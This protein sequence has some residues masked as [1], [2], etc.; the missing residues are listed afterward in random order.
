MNG[1]MG[2]ITYVD[3]TTGRIWDE[4]LND[5]FARKYLGGNGFGARILLDR[6]PK[7]ADPLGPENALI[8]A[9]GPLSGTTAHGS[10]RGAV[11]TKSPL[12]GLFMDSYFGGDFALKLKQSGRDAVVVMGRSPRPVVLLLDEKGPSILPAEDLWGL[13][14]LEVQDRLF[15]R[16]GGDISVLCCGPAGERLVPIACTIGGRRAAG[17]GGTGAVMGSKNLKAMAARGLRDIKVAD[18]K[19]LLRHYRETKERFLGLKSL[20]DIGTPYLVRIVNEFGGLGTRNWREETFEGADRI[21]GERLLEEHFV[22]HWAC[23]ACCMGGCTKVVRA[24]APGEVL[25]EGPEY[26]TLFALGSNCAVEELDWII[27]ADRICDDLGIDT[28]SFGSTLAFLMECYENGLITKEDTGGMELEFGKG[29]LLVECAK[30]TARREGIGELLAL[31]VRGASERIGQGSERLACHVRGLEPAGHSARALKCMG[32]GY[33]V[34]PRGGSHHDTRPG[35]EYRMDKSQR[36]S[37]EGKAR[38]A[39]ETSN[40]TAIGDSMVVCHFCEGVYGLTLQEPH[41][42]LVRLA[43]GWDVTLEELTGI[44]CRIHNAERI[45]N[46]R[47]G[48]SRKDDLLPLRFMEEEIPEGNSSGLATRPDELRQMLDEYYALRGWDER[49]LPREDTLKGLGMEELA[50][51]LRS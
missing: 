49:G 47:E 43:T 26:E 9:T 17:R 8:V 19:G 6:V 22:R 24:S 21:S 25:T 35:L 45:F 1:Y 42:E 28:I 38:L 31:G 3:L 40:W 16:L 4:P 51:I 20:K 37:I 39:Y 5:G 11:I 32:L 2:C 13:S 30:L 34:S 48:L 36:D 23:F 44:A 33:A 18:V 46:C 12:T 50:G 41:A 14:T 29:E 7:G 15:E 10:G 27:R